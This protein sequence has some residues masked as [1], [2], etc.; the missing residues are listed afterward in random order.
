MITS[1]TRPDGGGGGGGGSRTRQMSYIVR[2]RFYK[3]VSNA[4]Q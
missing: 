1:R 3:Q 2:K 4:G